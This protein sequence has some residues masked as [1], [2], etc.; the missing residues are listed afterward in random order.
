MPFSRNYIT[1]R[2]EFSRIILYPDFLVGRRHYDGGYENLLMLFVG[3]EI[4][5]ISHVHAGGQP[6]K[7]LRSNEAALKYFLMGSFATGILLFGIVL[8][9]G[10]TGTFKLPILR[11]YFC[12]NQRYRLNADDGN[13]CI[14]Y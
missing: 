1:E 11:R 10:A 7:Q 12:Q 5:S 2:Q 9:Y 6:Q 13:W 4:L 14:T 3:I 8:I